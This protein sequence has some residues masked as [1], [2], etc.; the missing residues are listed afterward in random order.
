M[1]AVRLW[2]HQQAAADAVDAQLADHRSTLV[3]CATGGGKTTTGAEIIRRRR[4]LG[5]V[6]WL[7]HREELIH[8]A[9]R[10]IH[11]HTGFSV[12]IEMASDHAR[13]L[14]D[15]VCASVQTLARVKRRDVF[16]PD[17][18][19]LVI[20]DE[21]FPA[22][23][24]VGGRQI[25]A[26]TVGDVVPSFDEATGLLVQ[27]RVTA[28]MRNPA[29]KLVRVVT[30]RG[31]ILCTAGHPFFEKFGWRAAGDLLCG[32]MVLCT[33]RE[34]SLR[35][36]PTGD[37]AAPKGQSGAAVLRR[38][39]EAACGREGTA[40]HAAMPSM[41][42]AGDGFLAGAER[43]D[44]RAPGPGVLLGGAQEGA[45]GAAVGGDHGG[46]QPK[47]RL[48]PHEGGQPDALAGSSRSHADHAARD[49]VE[50]DGARRQW[51]RPDS[52][53]TTTGVGTGMADGSR[54]K[55]G[56]QAQRGGRVPDELQ[57]RHRQQGAEGGDRGGRQIPLQP[58]G[59]G[60]QEGQLLA[61][62]RVDCVEVLEPG[63]DGTFGGVCPD[64]AVYN[65]EVEGTHTYVAGGFVVHNCHHAPSKTYRTILDHFPDAKVVGLTATPD[66]GDGVAMARVFESVAHVY[67]IRDA[68]R[69]G[70]LCRIKQRAIQVEGFDLRGVRTT[71]G[72]LNEGDL[73]ALLLDPEL[74]QQVGAAIVDAA[75]ARPTMVFAV[76]V[77]H[78]HALA[79]TISG[80]EAGTARALDGGSAPEL[81]KA[82]LADFRDG[83]FKR[84]VNCALFTEGFDEPTIACVAVARPTKSRAFYAQMLGRGLRSLA[85]KP[86][87]L[88]L[89]FQG[90][91]G[92]HRLIGP[93]DVLGGADVDPAVKKK[94]DAAL[95]A[96]PDL[97][98]LT[99]LETAARELAEE[100]R[101]KLLALANYRSV[102]VDP[103][104]LVEAMF[105]L[106]EKADGAGLESNVVYLAQHARGIAADRMK[107]SDVA[108]VATALRQRL[109]EG[110][111]SF[112]QARCLARAGLPFDVD[113]ATASRA[114]TAL[115]ANG[116]QPTPAIRAMFTPARV[117]PVNP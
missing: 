90:N 104:D 79:A 100:R 99:A 108:L 42:S 103:F 5:R 97:D 30:D 33:T 66:R 93:T 110:R 43:V 55:D 13:L 85:G 80:F 81:R 53:A 114:I 101:A 111:C 57:D 116:W 70:F 58:Q 77:A 87:C 62:A 112:A 1:T 15:V 83:K 45:Y 54:G 50:A 52:A 78:A 71:A 115:A 59:S 67:E 91:A 26:I 34:D 17:H 74:L 63:G 68:I 14:D 64:G 6:L 12:G 69:D 113:G 40:D 28:T 82:T 8:Q 27:R 109:R 22:G 61:W 24:L 65:L 117:P 39:Q 10:R 36:M 2:P 31:A 44:A 60:R 23:T 51:D 98:L 29:R 7:A 35:P 94:A 48:G 11:G 107:P 25:E 46:H 89:D 32:D 4:P 95:A 19:A 73:E 47:A 56:R 105:G 88:I 76:T 41:P 92:R 21:C 9:A 18:F 86:D 106:P 84:L 75:G 49:G 3:V 37:G 20:V 72:D 38:V 16:A 96:R 102:E